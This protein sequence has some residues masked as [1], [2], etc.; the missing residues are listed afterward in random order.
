MKQWPQK[1]SDLS[2]H[3]FAAVLRHRY[4]MIGTVPL[5]VR[6]ALVQLQHTFS[7]AVWLHLATVGFT[8]LPERSKLF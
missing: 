2:K 4:N 1:F 6:Q 8:L 3:R 5:R 7:P